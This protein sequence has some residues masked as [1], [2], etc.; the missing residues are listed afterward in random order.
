MKYT[1]T[2]LRGAI[3]APGNPDGVRKEKQKQPRVFV[4]YGLPTG[5]ARSLLFESVARAS[6]RE[7]KTKTVDET[8]W[9]KKKKKRGGPGNILI[10]DRRR[11]RRRGAVKTKM[12]KGRVAGGEGE[13]VTGNAPE[14][15]PAR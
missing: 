8:N 9:E 3:K 12:S 1:A 2:Q 4:L 6:R 11:R 7:G 15:L 14:R 13:G 5:C 10:F